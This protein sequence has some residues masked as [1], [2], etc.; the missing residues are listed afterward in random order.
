M[1]FFSAP[2]SI[3]TLEA[4]AEVLEIKLRHMPAKFSSLGMLSKDRFIELVVVSEMK[5]P[6]IWTTFFTEHFDSFVQILIDRD[7]VG[8]D[9]D[10]ST[11]A[12]LFFV[13]LGAHGGYVADANGDYRFV[14]RDSFEASPHPADFLM[15]EDAASRAW[16]WFSRIWRG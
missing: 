2:P 3:E 5:D 16:R 15:T 9:T 12:K 10:E 6:E 7:L 1:R 13:A 14:P 4:M 11:Q 8:T